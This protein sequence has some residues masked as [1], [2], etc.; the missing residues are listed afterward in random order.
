MYGRLN[1]SCLIVRA[2]NGDNSRKRIALPMTGEQAKPTRQNLDRSCWIRLTPDRIVDALLLEISHAGAKLRLRQAMELPTHF[3]VLLTR[4]G[5]VGRKAAVAS[6]A[7]N[8]FEVKFLSRTIPVSV[9]TEPDEDGDATIGP[10][11]VK[12]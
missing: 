4:D 9:D 12:V 8:E 11:I 10:D 1:A 2:Y 3:D 6:K 5:K 7:A